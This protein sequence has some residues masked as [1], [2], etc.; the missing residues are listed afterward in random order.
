[1][2]KIL[3]VGDGIVGMLAALSLSAYNNEI[4]LVKTK[5]DNKSKKRL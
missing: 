1:M 4:Y 5:P 3:I 2:K